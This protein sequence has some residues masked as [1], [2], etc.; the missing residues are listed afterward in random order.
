MTVPF[1]G[2]GLPDPLAEPQFYAGVSAKRLIAWIIDAIFIGALC[3][4]ILPFT[5]FTAL[6]FLPLLWLVTGFLYRWATIASSSATWGMRLMSIELREADGL[7]LS[8]TTALLHTLGYSVSV[9]VAPLQLISVIVMVTLGRGQ[10]LTDLALGTAMINR[11]SV[12]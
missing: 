9:G 4:L 2:P 6:F 11:P 10:G 1:S 8:G 7:R 3:F 12:A 5:A